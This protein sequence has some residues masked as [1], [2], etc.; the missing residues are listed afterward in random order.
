MVLFYINRRIKVDVD[1][2][3]TPHSISCTENF[4]L[5]ALHIRKN[6]FIQKLLIAPLI[7]WYVIKTASYEPIIFS[8]QLK[9]ETSY[10][11]SG[12]FM[13]IFLRAEPTNYI[14]EQ[15]T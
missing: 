3:S 6:I 9:D 15:Y 10:I 5:L 11:N 7:P 12:Q 4:C 13:E 2:S 8:L 14:S 1:L